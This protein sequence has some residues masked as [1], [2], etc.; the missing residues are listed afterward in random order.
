VFKVTAPVK[1]HLTVR[2]FVDLLFQKGREKYPLHR[3]DSR[4]C[5]LDPDGGH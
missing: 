5:I 4:M 2:T 1:N 3:G